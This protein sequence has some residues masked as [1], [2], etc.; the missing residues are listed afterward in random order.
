MGF[1]G[2]ACIGVYG[3]ILF[4]EPPIAH[5][6]RDVS[7]AG[8]IITNMMTAFQCYEVALAALVPALRGAHYEMIGHHTLTLVL[9]LLGG[10]YQYLYYYGPFFFGLS[11]LSSVGHKAANPA[12]ASLCVCVI[13]SPR[14][15]DLPST[16]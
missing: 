8:A 7:V 10:S 5:R 11:E 15:D 14:A 13:T 4:P 2:L 6:I 9:A 3:W 1:T 16:Y 12:S